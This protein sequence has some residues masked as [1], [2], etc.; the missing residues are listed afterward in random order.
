MY[1]G[2]NRRWVPLF[3]AGKLP[4]SSFAITSFDETNLQVKYLQKNST[5]LTNLRLNLSPFLSCLFAFRT[6]VVISYQFLI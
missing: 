6:S 4:Q 3:D 1:L 5:H 2:G